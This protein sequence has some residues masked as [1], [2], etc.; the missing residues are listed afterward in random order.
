ML[1]KSIDYQEIQKHVSSAMIRILKPHPLA[2]THAAI[3]QLSTRYGYPL[4][5]L[6]RL[7]QHVTADTYHWR[8]EINTERELLKKCPDTPPELSNVLLS[9][10]K[11]YSNPKRRLPYPHLVWHNNKSWIKLRKSFPTIGITTIVRP[12][13]NFSGTTTYNLAIGDKMVVCCLHLGD[14]ADQTALRFIPGTDLAFS[15]LIDE[16]ITA[17]IHDLKE[18]AYTLVMNKEYETLAQRLAASMEK[19]ISELRDSWSHFP[20]SPY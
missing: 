19:S 8:P 12:P 6:Q 14:T 2:I 17:D 18:A 4:Q 20:D 7:L 15:R 10:L 11:E 1:T 9:Y 5:Y 16:I 3:E 13:V